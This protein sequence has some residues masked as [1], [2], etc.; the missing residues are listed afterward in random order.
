MS[1]A[2]KRPSAEHAIGLVPCPVCKN[3]PL[4]RSACVDCGAAGMMAVDKAIALSLTVSDT[5][6][7]P[8]MVDE[9][10]P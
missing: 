10:E 2:S 9:E 7:A 1:P 4:R 8:A 3:D 6:P 5:D